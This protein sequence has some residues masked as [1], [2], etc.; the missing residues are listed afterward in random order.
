MIIYGIQFWRIR[1][2]NVSQTFTQYEQVIHYF[3]IT[4]EYMYM[5]QLKIQTK[6]I[7]C[8]I[9]AFEN[10]KISKYDVTPVLKAAYDK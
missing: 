8:I 7:F 10:R 2:T 1:H 9:S 4:N 5:N 6:Y 3:S